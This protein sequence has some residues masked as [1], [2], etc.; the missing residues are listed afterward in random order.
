MTTETAREEAVNP[1][2]GQLLRARG[3]NARAERRSR[4]DAPDIRFELRTGELV[5]I[6]CKW[7]SN[8][9]ALD[10]QLDQ[11]VHDFPDAVARVGV[12]YHDALKHVD[13]IQDELEYTLNLQWYLHSSRDQVFDD[14]TLR[15]GTIEQFA[16]HLRLLPL[17]IEGVDRV[18]AA[19]GAVGY[20][21][22]LAAS[23]L[24]NHARVARLIADAI[25]ETDD[26][27]D[28]A[29]AQ[30]IGCLVLFNALAFQ[31]RLAGLR[32]DV[33]SLNE[34]SGDDISKL[35]A[36]WRAICDEI[37]YVPVFELAADLAKILGYAPAPVPRLVLRP[38]LRA[39]EQT[40]LVEG[41]DLSGRLFHTLLSDA[42]FTGA[43]YTSVPAAT[44]LAR[45][46]FEG[47]PANVDWADHEFPG[48]LTVA[49]LACGTGT[50]L[51][52]VA[53][54]AERRHEAA[55]G[56]QSA[57]LHKAMV[58]QAL[59]GYD[60]QL[61]AI[62]FA[63]TSLAMLNPQIEFDRMNLYVMDYG[64]EDGK[65]ALGSLDFLLDD[66]VPVQLALSP[67]QSQGAE[68]VS[69]EGPQ[70]VEA[71]VTA[72]LP[73]LDLAIMNP[74]F[75][76]SVGGNLLFGSLPKD[77]RRKLQDELSR[78]LKS[79]QATATA[80]LG[81]AFVAATAPK[82]RPGEGRIAL[83][84]PA[85]VC[86]GPSW[87]QTRALIERDFNLD[88]VIVSHDPT[89]W[90][91]SDS[92]DLS[93]ALLIATRRSQQEETDD[94][95]TSFVNLWRNSP[96]VF[97]A[98]RVADAIASTTPAEFEESGSALLTVD[99]QHMGE[100]VSMPEARLNGG[101]WSGVQFARADLTRSAVRLLNDGELLVPGNG[102]APVELCPL[103]ELGEIGPDR[104]D[105]WDG[106]ERTDAITAYPMVENHDTD[107]RRS[108]AASADKYLAPL[109]EA[110]PGRNL[111]PLN[112]LWPKAGRLLISERLWLNTTR[113]V[114]MCADRNVL[115][116]VFWPVKP[117]SE[118][119]S[120][121]L[122]VWLNSS[123]GLLTL[124]ARRTTTRA[125]WS[126]MKKADLKRLPVLDV[127]QLTDDQLADLS[128]LF[129]ELANASFERLPAM[130]D[131]PTRTRLDEGLSEILGLP[132]LL[133]LRRLLASEPVVSN[134]RL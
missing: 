60:V 22:D 94:H 44:M 97:E 91:F 56:S 58:E 18:V 92:T 46:V 103:G 107:R 4:G 132:N 33:P 69:G 37:D 110:R 109:V 45:L 5:L 100:V 23:E 48:S 126:A 34:V 68:R 38:L 63:A 77:E 119:W 61:S 87:A 11:R 43:Y 42:K 122:A 50:L 79:R 125:G 134:R 115:S 12:L 19:A 102:A 66:E 76:R 123:L 54:E 24:R 25:A 13:D 128:N 29:S 36:A 108:M 85:T 64:A 31:D 104:R 95:R 16:D 99:G 89:R 47:W 86:T 101:K 57:E 121:P 10:A 106:F 49:D 27:K 14:Q 116:N 127:R 133:P 90:N 75:T 120:E 51:M 82:L 67:T 114:A 8:R 73:E 130:V 93:E 98:G 65:A 112:T 129:D 32:D 2:L 40:R 7:E 35:E 6:E 71:G 1:L 41:H 74:P 17:E 28:K 15:E 118:S 105:L 80:G 39:V 3:I 20:A 124:L 55:G 59:H 62:H 70:G 72:K 30:R 81:A 52:A 26:E 9:P 131:C 111:K 96:S 84:L 88:T 53:A 83:V 21:L 78:R 117:K 113:I